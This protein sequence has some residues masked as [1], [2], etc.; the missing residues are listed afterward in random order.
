MKRLAFALLFVAALTA[1]AQEFFDRL[2]RALT[3]SSPDN[4]IRAR[5]SGTL[6]L[7]TYAFEKPPPGLIIADENF[8]F[9]P[10]LTLFLDAQVGSA[11]YAFVQTRVDRGFDPHDAGAQIRL[12]E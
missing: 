11:F 2:D 3:F 7:E 12:D 9:N 4:S 1:N 8:L 5:L 6:D 10:R